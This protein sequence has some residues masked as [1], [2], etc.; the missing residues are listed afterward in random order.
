VADPRFLISARIVDP[1]P[2]RRGDVDWAVPVPNPTVWRLVGANNRELGRSAQSYVDARACRAGV[3]L[4]QRQLPQLTPVV[5]S[6]G[7]GRWL[8]RLDVDKRP[9]AMAARS[10]LRQR[11]AHYNLELFLA[12]VPVARLPDAPP[13]PAAAATSRPGATGAPGRDRAAGSVASEAV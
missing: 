2:A 1:R 11:E 8:W 13:R 5:W 3:T 12:S 6:D 9:T 7:R 10:Y 4:L